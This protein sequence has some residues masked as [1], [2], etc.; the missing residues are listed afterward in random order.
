MSRS[1]VEPIFTLEQVALA[2][3]LLVGLYFPTSIDGEHSVKIV[4]GGFV[5]LLLL[6]G[7]LAWKKGVHGSVAAFIS[8]PILIVL[9]GC[10]VAA[11]IRG[12]VDLDP[13]LLVRFSALALVLSLNLQ[14][15]RPGPL[16]NGAFVLANLVNIACGIA[17]LVG[18]EPVTS[19][20]PKYYWT[21]DSN[22]VP[23]MMSLHKPVLTF[24]SHALGGLFTYLFFWMNWEDFRLRGKKLSLLFA[25]GYFLLL[26]GLMSFTSIGFAALAIAQIAIWLWKRDPKLTA[27]ARAFAEEIGSLADLPQIADAAF[28]NSDFSGPAA[29]YGAGGS[30]GPAI[31][32]MFRHPLSPIGLARSA[33]AFDIES[34]SHFFVGDSGPVE[35]LLRGS[36][37]LLFLIYFGFYR[38]LRNNLALNAHCRLLFF[39][40][41]AFEAGY[42]ALDSSRTFFLLPFLVIYLN[43]AASTEV[44]RP[45]HRIVGNLRQAFSVQCRTVM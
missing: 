3:L 24:G 7:Y 40:I 12:P 2:C 34:S 26:L 31:T 30:L 38:F 41:L 22:L 17:V 23:L 29:R 19:F 18:L 6:L 37:P 36:V 16:V 10:S 43:Q 14:R 20:I 1:S 39:S 33:S 8:M 32:Y 45:T 35:Y 21:S 5:I 13:G 4:L 27:V 9:V 25:L 15:L 28:L 42:S 11:L 44:I